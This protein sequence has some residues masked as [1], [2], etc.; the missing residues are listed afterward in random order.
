MADELPPLAQVPQSVSPEMI[1]QL[2]HSASW[3]ETFGGSDTNIAQRQRHNQDITDYATALAQQRAEHQAALLQSDKHAQDLYFRTQQMNLQAN[4]AAQR[5]Q[6][7]AELQPIKIQAQQAQIA[8]DLAR[9]KATVQSSLVQAAKAKSQ[10]EQQDTADSDTL[11]F[12]NGESELAQR[13]GR[14]SQAYHN[15]L[16]DLHVATPAAD[17]QFK[18]PY[19]AAAISATSKQDPIATGFRGTPEEARSRYGPNATLHET[20]KGVWTV[21]LPADAQQKTLDATDRAKSVTTA[22]ASVDTPERWHKDLKEMV[23]QYG[24]EAMVPQHKWREFEDRK[25]K[26]GQPPVAQPAAV[27]VPMPS[28]A[29]AVVAPIPVDK[30]A[31]AKA[32]LGDPNASEAHKAA[33]RKILLNTPGS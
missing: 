32:A 24:G 25:A 10:A 15:G 4:E 3:A 17:Q 31:L 30:V 23:D 13:F 5:M 20:S 14:N 16:L 2:E 19:V 29:A 6:H 28:G 21:T 1:G 8:A 9:E 7:A 27:V 11:K 33:A 26:I 12:V 22:R 18:T